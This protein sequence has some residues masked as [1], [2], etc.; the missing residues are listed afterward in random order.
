MWA[1]SGPWWAGGK[2]TVSKIHELHRL[3]PR[4]GRGLLSSRAIKIPHVNG[5]TVC[6]LSRVSMGPSFLFHNRPQMWFSDQTF[7]SPFLSSPRLES[8]EWS[9]LEKSSVLWSGKG[10]DRGQLELQSTTE[11]PG[12]GQA[13]LEQERSEL[14]RVA[15]R[16]QALLPDSWNWM[17]LWGTPGKAS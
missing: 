14:S 17:W 6:C 3:E 2:A 12:K 16:M 9:S 13:S 8:L 7:P 1:G 11:G 15:H 10:A 4:P 5:V